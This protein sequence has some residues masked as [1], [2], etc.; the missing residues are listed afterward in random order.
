MSNYRRVKIAGGQ[1]FFTLVTYQR[2]DWL[3]EPVAREALRSAIL[4]V[5]QK[6]PFTIDAIVLLPDHLHCI[7]T[8]P[9]GDG[10]YSM[11]WSLIK[12]Y[13]TQYYGG[14]INSSA[15]IGESRW[16]RREGNLW[17]RRF[18]ENQ[19]KNDADYQYCCDYIHNN[20]VKHGLCAK[21]QD[22]PYSS[23]HRFDV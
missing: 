11:R 20:P 14:R 22:W 1:Y 4:H 19:V 5:R 12:R 2:Q 17:Q 23:I 6:Y 13:V 3:C 18:W 15:T 8:L 10:N 7:W 9:N 21:P 16:N